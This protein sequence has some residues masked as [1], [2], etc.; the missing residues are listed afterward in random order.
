MSL[1]DDRKTP[2]GTGVLLNE[3]D[4]NA[5]EAILQQVCAVG[6]HPAVDILLL[7]A[8]LWSPQRTAIDVLALVAAE[9]IENP[10]VAAVLV[11]VRAL[12]FAGRPTSPQLVLDELRRSGAAT[13]LVLGHLRAAVT[14]GAEP[15]AVNAYAAAVVA[16]SLRRRISSAGRAMVELADDGS[17]HDLAQLVAK[18]AAA[19]KA[20][21]V[22]LAALRGES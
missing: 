1:P 11:A 8:L 17:E 19:I 16:A 5:D 18:S 4:G 20:T 21:A 14:S 6:P 12:A 15:L 2:A 22:R 10:S 7:G 13:G 3:S 9:D